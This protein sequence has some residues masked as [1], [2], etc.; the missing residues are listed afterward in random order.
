MPEEPATRHDLE[1]LRAHVDQRFQQIDSRFEQM[2]SR[3]EQIDSRFEQLQEQMRDMQTELLKA[4]LPWQEQVRIEFRRLEANT[5]N[6]VTAL[7][8]R[9]EV[10]ERRLV[11]IEKKL[12]LNPPQAGPQ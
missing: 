12:L 4:F 8:M 2:D 3:F 10:L 5:G 11:E 6:D 7:R 9:V 1:L